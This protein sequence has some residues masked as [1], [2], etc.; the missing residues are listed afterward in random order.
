MQKVHIFAIRLD[1]EVLH[2]PTFRAANP[3]YVPG[4]PCYYVGSSPHEPERAFHECKVGE[5]RSPWVSEH[6]L[7]VAKNRCFVAEVSNREQREQA[8]KAHAEEL[9]ALGCGICRD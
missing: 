8:E 6:G 4:Q 7:Y 9:R 1:A 2:K 5:D 3:G